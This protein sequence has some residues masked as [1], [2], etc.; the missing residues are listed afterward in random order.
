MEKARPRRLAHDRDAA[1]T[2]IPGHGARQKTFDAVPAS[3]RSR[4]LP[5]GV[6][7]C[8]LIADIS[9]SSCIGMP[10][11][12]SR[13]LYLRATGRSAPVTSDACRAL[14]GR[15]LERCMQSLSGG[16]T[17]RLSMHDKG[18]SVFHIGWV[19][20]T[21]LRLSRNVAQSIYAPKSESVSLEGRQKSHVRLKLRRHAKAAGSSTTRDLEIHGNAGS[22]RASRWLAHHRDRAQRRADRP[23]GQ[24]KSAVR[25]GEW[26]R[27]ESERERERELQTAAA[28]PAQRCTNPWM[29]TNRLQN[30]H[31]WELPDRSCLLL[32]SSQPGKRTEL[33]A[34]K[35]GQIDEDVDKADRA[36]YMDIYRRPGSCSWT[37]TRPS[38]PAPMTRLD[39]SSS[40]PLTQGP[41]TSRLRPGCKARRLSDRCDGGGDCFGKI[42]AAAAAAAARRTPAD[43]TMR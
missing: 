16:R 33:K 36:H 32:C 21:C 18:C 11:L 17:A 8:R 5:L 1:R 42:A 6:T 43:A 13:S 26:E 20:M 31:V 37:S 24:N 41:T 10:R 22:A 19:P 3:R 39:E 12:A 35:A 38:L 14:A 25:A 30:K 28:W 40:A 29:S 9:H 15:I 7:A 4:C 34:A 2:T 27:E 23:R